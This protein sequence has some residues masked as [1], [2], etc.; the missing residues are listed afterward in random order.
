MIAPQAIS[1]RVIRV[2]ILAAEP[3]RRAELVETLTRAGHA[4]ADDIAAADAVLSVDEVPDT[5]K[6]LITL[7]A[8]DYG[9][10]GALPCDASTEQIDAAVRAAAAGLSVRPTA[11]AAGF[12]AV[13][14]RSI[15]A[16]LTPR[17]VEILSAIAAGLSNK[18]IARHFHISLHTVKFHVESLF[19]KLGARTRAEAVARSLE[20][21]R[22][23]LQI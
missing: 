6:P 23:Q 7:G 4:A 21:R 22:E 2:A 11:L 16:L 8:G 12:G 13:R 18:G 1:R 3:A 10:V 14:E 20:L 17:E 5:D 9:Q 19:R 15:E